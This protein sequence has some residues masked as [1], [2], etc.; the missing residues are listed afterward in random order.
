I[1]VHRPARPRLILRSIDTDID[2]PFM[3]A[4]PDLFWSP[5]P[6]FRGEF[7]GHPVTIN[8]LGLRGAELREPRP[9]RRILCLGDS[10][11]FGYGVG[12]DETYA[13][14]LG[15]HLAAGGAEVVNGGVTGYTSHQVRKRL[16]LVGP[17]LRPDDV[18]I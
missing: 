17:V 18:V 3:R 13:A 1:G 2:L 11:T 8:R 7:R 16:A 15:R 5:R 4:D 12:D 9:A 14:A 6:G 10:I